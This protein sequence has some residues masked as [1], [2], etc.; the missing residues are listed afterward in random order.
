MS[1]AELIET[2]DYYFSGMENNDG[3]GYYPFTDDCI[4]FENGVDVLGRS[5]PRATCKGQFETGLKGIVDRIRDRRYVAV[6]REK[7]IVFAFGFFDHYRINWT[8]QLGELF[9]IE[10]G[11]IRRIEAIFHRAP[12][13]MNSGWSTYEEGLSSEI[14]DVR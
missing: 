8:W 4:R 14:Q 5:T 13:G 10:N 12:F 1:R 6:D 2:A 7:G 9:K 3:K 11:Q